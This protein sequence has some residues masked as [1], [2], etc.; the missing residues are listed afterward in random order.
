MDENHS[1]QSVAHRRLFHFFAVCLSIYLSYVTYLSHSAIFTSGAQT[2]IAV[3]VFALLSVGCYGSLCFLCARMPVPSA[4]SL[5]ITRTIKQK[6]LFVLMSL[7][8]TLGLLWISFAA[9]YPGAVSY[10]AANQWKQA[11]SGEFN[12]WHPVFHTLLIW[13]PMQIVPSYSFALITQ[14]IAFAVVFAYWLSMIYEKGVP[15]WILLLVQAVIV[16]SPAVSNPM[17][18][19]WKD[20][21]LTIGMVLLFAQ[22]T[23]ILLSDGQW[24]AKPSHVLAL[25]FTLAFATLVR[26]NSMFATVPFACFLFFCYVKERKQTLLAI[27]TFIITLLLIQGGLFGMLDIVYP[28]NTADESTGIPMTLLANAKQT[29]PDALSVE[30]ND[31]LATLADEDA[32]QNVYRY[33]NYNSIKFTYYRELVSKDSD[34]FSILQMAADVAIQNPALAFDTFNGLTDL[35]WG[36]DG[37][38]EAVETVVNSGDLSSVPK[39]NGRINSLG[40][41]IQSIIRIP[42]QWSFVQYFSDN[43]GVSLLLFFLV[44]LVALYQIGSSALLFAMGILVYHFGT[45][46]LL[47]SNDARFFI[48]SMVVIPPA[49][50]VLWLKA[51]DHA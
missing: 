40:Q 25:G 29:D 43:I 10:D 27:A 37:Q 15:A 14:H 32:W 7:L 22:G 9:C 47:A 12:N 26:H 13:I 51:R 18:Y 41:T 20:N 8:I 49:C 33:N 42:Y 35:V 50:I 3:I 28:N 1:W 16:A 24:L 5:P 36:I 21:A 17:M 30:A 48:F 23:R 44:T 2:V 46:L 31:F 39:T 45:M 34:I 19:L 11:V 4:H 38:N 6:R